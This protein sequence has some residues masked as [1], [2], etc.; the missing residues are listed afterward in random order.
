[1]SCGDV[2]ASEAAQPLAACMTRASAAAAHGRRKGTL[3]VGAALAPIAARCASG[4]M[5]PHT[6]LRSIQFR[7]SGGPHLSGGS[8][9]CA[10]CRPVCFRRHAAVHHADVHPRLLPHITTLQQAMLWSHQHTVACHI[11][12]AHCLHTTQT[13]AAASFGSVLLPEGRQAVVPRGSRRRGRSTQGALG[14]LLLPPLPRPARHHNQQPTTRRRRAEPWWSGR[15]LVPAAAPAARGRC[16]RR[17]RAAPR[18]PP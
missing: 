10:R 4:G 17:R 1:M 7:D 18:H 15:A 6:M 14:L 5:L 12:A 9:I 3:P 13:R 16:R 2:A 11:P 8:S